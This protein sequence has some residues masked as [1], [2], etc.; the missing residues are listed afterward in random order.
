MGNGQATLYESEE[1][2]PPPQVKHDYIGEQ[3]GLMKGWPE[4][5]LEVLGRTL[6]YGPP[7]KS[8]ENEPPSYGSEY[9]YILLGTPLYVALAD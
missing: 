9:P 8:N 1:V 7:S 6:I 3:G 4:Q 5:R 2:S